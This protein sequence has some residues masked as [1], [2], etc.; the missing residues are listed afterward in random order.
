VYPR[1]DRERYNIRRWW[2][3]MTLR[4][5]FDKASDISLKKIG[6]MDGLGC[7]TYSDLGK[8]VT[9]WQSV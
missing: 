3:G 5:R 9:V 7:W 1:D 4:D 6:L 8:T 2:L